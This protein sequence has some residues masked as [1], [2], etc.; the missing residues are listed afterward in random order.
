VLGLSREELGHIYAVCQPVRLH[1]SDPALLCT[2]L[3]GR[4]AAAYPE[5][6]SKVAGLSPAH[7]YLLTALVQ[8][9]Q[10]ARAETR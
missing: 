8:E 4:L 1:D 7:R 6:S 9:H 3:V 2:F 5:P 10:A